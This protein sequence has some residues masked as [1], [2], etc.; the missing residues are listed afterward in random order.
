VTLQRDIFG[1]SAAAVM[2]GRLLGA[3]EAQS[4]VAAG[5]REP[6]ELLHAAGRIRRYFFGRRVSFC[7]IAPGRL[8]GCDQDCAWCGQSVAGGASAAAQEPLSLSQLS[9]SARRA[10]DVGAACF[11]VVNPGRMPRE[12]D[13]SAIQTLNATLAREQLAPACAS[14]GELDEPT[15][16]RL[17]AT[18]VRRY[19][20]NLETSR[21]H[22]G[23][24][25]TT[26]CY[27]DRLATLRA[28]RAAGMQ[29]CCGG[30]FGIGES[31]ADRIELAL[32]LRDHVDPEVVP[33]NF[34]DPRPG[35]RLAQVEPLS[36]MECMTI[37]ALFRFLL[38]ATNLKVAGGRRLLGDL[39]SWAFEAGAT[40]LMV[41]DYLTTTG[42]GVEQDLQMVRDLDLD[43]VS[44][45]NLR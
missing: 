33:L 45:E 18:G 20:H 16:R 39:Q 29:L 38:P 4:L 27:D 9:S 11:C 23:R 31:W 15:A 35:S 44:M 3:P 2:S 21:A 22:F 25:V 8:G 17:R 32:T 14:F 1:Q 24:V 36:S 26:H 19:N 12:V 7:C 5:L 30:L 10:S 40:S 6:L 37:I 42:R 43:L 41:G 28:A 34:L 13:L